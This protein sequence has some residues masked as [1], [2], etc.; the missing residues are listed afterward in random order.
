[1]ELGSMA[2]AAQPA[3][4]GAGSLF[5]TLTSAGA[6]GYG[7][8]IV[9]GAVQGGMLT[10]G[11]AVAGI[12]TWAR[13]KGVTEDERQIATQPKESEQQTSEEGA[14]LSEDGQGEGAHEEAP[15]VEGVKLAEAKGRLSKL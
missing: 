11:S 4:V 1:M 12:N 6:G 7:V 8:P 9:Y 10:L 5:A 2:A 13:K 3:A 14:N 15:T